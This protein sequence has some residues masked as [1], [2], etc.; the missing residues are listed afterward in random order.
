MHKE[1]DKKGEMNLWFQCFG[2]RLTYP[3]LSRGDSSRQAMLPLL[4]RNLLARERWGTGQAVSLPCAVL[5]RCPCLSRF[6]QRCLQHPPHRDDAVSGP[7]PLPGRCSS[8]ALCSQS[9]LHRLSPVLMESIVILGTSPINSSNF[10]SKAM[11][12]EREKQPS[13]SL[14]VCWFVWTRGYFGV[15]TLPK[16]PS[17]C[18]TIPVNGMS[19]WASEM[20]SAALLTQNNGKISCLDLPVVSPCASTALWGMTAFCHKKSRTFAWGWEYLTCHQKVFLW[21]VIHWLLLCEG[22]TLSPLELMERPWLTQLTGLPSTVPW[23][24]AVAKTPSALV[25]LQPV[26]SLQPCRPLQLGQL[27]LSGFGSNARIIK[28]NLRTRVQKQ[29][30]TEDSDRDFQDI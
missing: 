1:E 12:M 9:L 26:V 4:C 18:K 13:C 24:D 22:L 11:D 23:D 6:Q 10:S 28:V 2:C 7:Q 21:L 29:G 30:S 19:E 15:W 20:K 3:G 17:H 16:V 25:C 27:G 5:A 14:A 8:H